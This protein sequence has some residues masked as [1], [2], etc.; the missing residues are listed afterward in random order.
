MLSTLAT[1]LPIRP[2]SCYT[3]CMTRKK[4]FLLSIV[5]PVLN[6]E[7]NIDMLLDT[8]LPILKR[9]TYELVFVNDG[10]KD[11][12]VEKI[13]EVT[14]KH[15]QIK[16]VS[17]AR[18]FGHQ[19][20]LTAGYDYIKGDV[21]ISMDADLQDPPELIH[22]MIEKWQEGFDIVYAQRKNRNGSWFKKQSGLW[23]YDLINR[24]SEVPI[25]QDVGDFRLLD[26]K[27][28]DILNQLP[29]KSR[30]LRGLVAWSGF[31][32]TYIQFTRQERTAGETHYPLSKM[33]SFALEGITSFSTRP[34]RVASYLGFLTAGL[35]ILGILYAI[36]VRLFLPHSFW[37]TGWTGLFVAI[38]FFGGVQ[39][40]SIGI[41]GEYIGKIYKQVQ[42]RPH[43]VVGETANI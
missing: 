10:S 18:N 23:F 16:L 12:T 7:E 38:T 13:K 2:F 37:V 40:I 32:S 35:G 30:F 20:A 34:L 6:E 19:M 39:L 28:V 11:K 21:V 25:P 42:Q 14:E 36:G 8:L 29:E 43:Y 3:I 22:D 27:V 33:V 24:L 4:S 41:I 15:P 1:T 31:P 17:F 9:Y 26:R 5:I